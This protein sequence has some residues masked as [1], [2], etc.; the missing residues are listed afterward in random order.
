MIA[1]FVWNVWMDVPKKI[2]TPQFAIMS[3]IKV[4]Y[5]DGYAQKIQVVLYV[6]HQ[7]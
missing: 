1:Q 4:V 3:F 5:A 7:S 6:V 2:T